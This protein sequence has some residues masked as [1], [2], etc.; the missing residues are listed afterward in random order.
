MGDY[1]D[2][3]EDLFGGWYNGR[4]Y[5]YCLFILKYV[6]KLEYIEL[7]VWK[8]VLK[9]KFIFFFIVNKVGDYVKFNFLM[10]LFVYLL[11]WGLEI[12]KDVY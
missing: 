6:I 12:W 10:V 8:I 4:L 5:W 1:G 11:L 9:L 3:G 7:K 2:Y